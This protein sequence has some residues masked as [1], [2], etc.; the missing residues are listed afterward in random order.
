MIIS[1]VLRF[2][3]TMIWLFLAAIPKRMNAA[4][5]KT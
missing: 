2:L 3:A 4:V 5:S 1:V